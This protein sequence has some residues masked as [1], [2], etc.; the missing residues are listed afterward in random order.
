MTV[1]SILR[2]AKS[3]WDDPA[4]GD[5]D[6]PLNHRGRHAAERVG[7]ELKLRGVHF[8]HVL[9]SPA[10]RVRET[11]ERLERGYGALPPVTFDQ[12]L[13]AASGAA[14]L[15]RVR[16]LSGEVQ[17]PLLVGHNPGMHALLLALTVDDEDGLRERVR[18][19]YPTGAF[20]MMILPAVRWDEVAPASGQIRE[21]IL[22]R[23]LD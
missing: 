7:R 18:D 12:A 2:H 8:D 4:L 19:K 1:L 6:R 14:L 20:A 17:A 16:G 9:A 21:L 11:L 3:S 10:A 15:D 13:Y 23:D 22:P 5:F